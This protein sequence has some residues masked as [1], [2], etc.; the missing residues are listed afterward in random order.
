MSK[1]FIIKTTDKCNLNCSYCY[2]SSDTN[3]NDFSDHTLVRLFNQIEE[4][5]DEE[6]N[7]IWHGGEPLLRG[8]V[9]FQRIIEL[10]NSSSKKIINKIQTNGTLLNEEFADFFKEHDFEVGISIDGYDEMHL[11][12]RHEDKKQ[13]ITIKNNIKMLVDKGVSFGIISV[14]HKD[15]IKDPDKYIEF[16]SKL[17]VDSV[18][19]NIE[20]SIAV[21]IDD[22]LSEKYYLFLKGI[23]DHLDKNNISI[24]TREIEVIIDY[25]MKRH[26]IRL[27][28]YSTNICGANYTG[29]DAKG[30]IYLL[31][32]R[33]FTDKSKII[34]NINNGNLQQIIHSQKI[35]DW[36]IKLN[37]I[38][39]ICKEECEIGDFCNG[40]CIADGLI[41]LENG[42]KVDDFKNRLICKVRR[43]LF[44]YISNDFNGE[45]N[46]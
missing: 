27:C 2:H 37:M 26:S 20:D 11:G 38:R 7:I 40:G 8:I 18:S 1:T 31:C 44:K 14:I 3:K 33:F 6:I 35:S 32:D 13:F 17:G 36:F 29:I 9:F 41:A 28:Q 22:D 46:G 12:Y 42:M 16:M 24:K 15:N 45:Q 10:E 25:L 19:L 4:L 21:N 30:N 23:Y 39:K 5:E 43:K 34:G